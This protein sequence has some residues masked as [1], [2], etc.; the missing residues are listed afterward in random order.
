MNRF[1]SLIYELKLGTIVSGVID[2]YTSKPKQREISCSCKQI[3]DILGLEIPQMDIL[4]I[5]TG[6]GLECKLENGVIRAYVPFMRED[7]ENEYDLAEEVIRIYG[8]SA[9]DKLQTR[10]FENSVVTEGKLDD[11]TKLE[12]KIKNSLVAS[13]YYEVLN[14]SLCPPDI[15]E[16]LNITD[17]RRFMIKIAN[18]ISEEISHLRSTMAHSLLTSIAYNISV[19]NKELSI[20][21]AG[22]TYQ[23]K[24]LPLT[25]LPTETNF[26]G[27]AS[28]EKDFYEFKGAVLNAVEQTGV[29]YSLLR[30]KQTYLHPGRSADVVDE[31]ENVVATFGQIHPLV[32]K[33]YDLP[34]Q[35]MYGEINLDLLLPYLEKHFMVKPV[36][37][38]PIVERDLAIVV[39]EEIANSD[40]IAAIKSACGKLFYEVKLFDIYRSQSLGEGVKSLAYNIKLSDENKTLTDQ[41]VT[42]VMARVIKA[43]KFRYGASLR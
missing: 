4:K 7:L 21:E 33:N 14:Y 23:P 1:L 10:L 30:S 35:T 32:A 26:I 27:L 13:G 18:P 34:K 12:R 37:K 11:R 20:F 19:G 2:E 17:N 36:S 39:K 6:L 8:Y 41:E 40:L 29:K 15:C 43:L 38:F 9:Y 31:N 5:L 22:R 25:E 28:T 3:W 42:D 24:Q 16:K